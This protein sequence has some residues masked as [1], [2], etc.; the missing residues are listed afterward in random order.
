MSRTLSDYRAREPKE[1]LARTLTVWVWVVSAAVLLLVGVMG[2]VTIPVSEGLLHYFSMLPMVNA[3]LN[4]G[5]AVALVLAFVMIKLGKPSR[6]QQCM[7]SAFR[8]SALFLISY[9]LYHFTAGET[10]FGD[11]DGDGIV[12]A[13]EKAEAGG[14]RTFYL[15][16][17]MSHIATAAIGLPF[18][19]LTFVYAM[20]NQFAKHRRMARWVF[21]LWL[22]IAVTGPAVY[23]L[24]RPYY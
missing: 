23:L 4:T 17:L 5:T 18:I 13:A 3:V 19:L 24:L 8:L 9:V 20:T 16:L 12:S 6:H 2:R 11:A 14:L 15:A 21:P 22:Y 1:R 10:K 7:E